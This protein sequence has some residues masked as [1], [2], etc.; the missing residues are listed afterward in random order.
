MTGARGLPPSMAKKQRPC[1][2]CGRFTSA[3]KGV[4]GPCQSVQRQAYTG[5]P[6]KPFH[7]RDRTT[8]SGDR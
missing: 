8:G 7:L 3:K 2:R 5:G 4:C 6:T 1:T